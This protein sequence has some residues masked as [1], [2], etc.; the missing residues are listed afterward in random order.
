MSDTELDVW[1]EIRP[2]VRSP[3]AVLRSVAAGLERKSG[4]ALRAEIATTTSDSGK[5]S[6][7]LQV[8]APELAGLQQGVLI[9]EYNSSAVYPV[10]LTS[11]FFPKR[12]NEGEKLGI[13]TT[14]ADDVRLTD[15]IREVLRSDAVVGL[16]NSLLARLTER[17]TE[18][19]Q[20]A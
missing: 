15:I 11:A 7:E 13:V 4:G 1:P 3:L 12:L 6:H 17:L 18:T 16:I 8:V 19:A 2:V 14:A 20:P 10:R 5:V 9:L